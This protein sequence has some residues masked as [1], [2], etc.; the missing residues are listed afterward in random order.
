MNQQPL[1]KKI[2]K[3]NVPDEMEECGSAKITKNIEKR[4]GKA[5][6]YTEV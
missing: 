3:K 6:K 4:A 5:C 2:Q 1:H